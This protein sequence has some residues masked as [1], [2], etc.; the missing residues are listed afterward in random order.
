MTHKDCP[1]S[2]LDAQQSMY[3]KRCGAYLV[4]MYK[5]FT[6]DVN[7]VEI[8]IRDLPMLHCL[9]CESDAFP[10]RSS[11]SIVKIWK[12]AQ[13]RNAPR[14][15]VTRRKITSVFELTAIPFVYDPDDYYYIPGLWRPRDDGILQPVYFNRRVL[16]KY[17]HAEGYTL[18]FGSR[19]Y[20]TIRSESLLISFGINPNNKVVMWLGNIAQLPD[21][22]QWYLKSENIPSDHCIGSEFYD[23]QIECKFT[24]FSQED[25]VIEKRSRFVESAA[26]YFGTRIVHLDEETLDLISDFRQPSVMNEREMKH[27]SIL[28]CQVCIET[29]DIR[30]LDRILQLRNIIPN[31]D[32]S[33]KKL[34]KAFMCDF[35]G[36]PISSVLAPFFVAYDLRVALAHNMSRARRQQLVSSAHQRLG[37][38]SNEGWEVVYSNLLA[39]LAE[40]YQKLSCLMA[41][42]PGAR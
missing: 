1:D 22:E 2:D 11:K 31:K 7:G 24:E 6:N 27:L 23:G 39:R 42:G 32:G 16:I 8:R 38:D 30:T 19:T 15:D 21:S 26:A 18:E 37:L 34:E 5:D 40:S 13:D 12:D 9:N 25:L 17:D 33:L 36:A 4:L 29:I 35:P 28:I 10:L 20:G 41:Q 3:C 14:V